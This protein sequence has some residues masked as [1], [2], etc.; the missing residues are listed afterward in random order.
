MTVLTAGFVE[1]D[2]RVTILFA[3]QKL[4]LIKT[5]CTARISDEM[6]KRT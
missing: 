2:V 6:L 5:D 4:S 1:L 3:K